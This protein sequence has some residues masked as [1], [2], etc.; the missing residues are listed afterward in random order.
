MG[1]TLLFAGTLLVVLTLKYLVKPAAR[2]PECGQK[3]ESDTPICPC[4]WI[5]EYPEDDAPLEY[6]DPDSTP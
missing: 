1:Y 2:C 4:G 5:F 6:G 3:R